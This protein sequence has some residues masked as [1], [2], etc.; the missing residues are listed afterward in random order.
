MFFKGLV[1]GPYHSTNIE[2]ELKQ[3]CSYCWL[4]ILLAL[5][6][7]IFK[8]QLDKWKQGF[9]KFQP[10]C[11]FRVDLYFSSNC[12]K[13]FYK[14]GRHLRPTLATTGLGYIIC[15]R[16]TILGSTPVVSREVGTPNS[17]RSLGTIGGTHTNGTPLTP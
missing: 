10:T 4:P 6:D 9:L 2:T 16:A 7:R 13:A 14:L 8:I 12:A 5:F 1:F 11:L 17:S 15:Q 3:F